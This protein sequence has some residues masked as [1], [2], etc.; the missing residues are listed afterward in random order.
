MVALLAM[1]MV[2]PACHGERAAAPAPREIAAQKVVR[3]TIE[4]KVLFTGNIEAQDAVDIFPRASGKVSQKLFKE[5]DRVKKGQALLLIDRDE[6][7]YAFR[8]MPVDAPIDGLVGTIA[9]DVGSNVDT[10]DAVVT[11]VRAGDMRVKLDVPERYLTTVVPGTP[12]TMAVDSLDGEAF[13]GTIATASPVIDR[14]TRTARVE[15]RVPHTDGRLRHGM[16]GRMNLVVER[17]DGVLMVPKDAISWEGD[18]QFVYKVVEGKVG[19]QQVS[20]GLRNEE[21]VEILEGA[22]EG[23]VVAVGDLLDL[24]EGEPAIA[25]GDAGRSVDE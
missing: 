15:I 8:S 5:G 7:G 9:V 10:Q 4:R 21:H 25:K 23:D 18:K 11:I 16:F 13:A 17:R 2:L 12:V 24:K 6:I 20:I 3:G 14:K 1:A 19:R 22:A